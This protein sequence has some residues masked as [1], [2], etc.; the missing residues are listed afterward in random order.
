MKFY[1]TL[2]LFFG[3]FSLQAQVSSDCSIP[4]LLRDIYDRDVKGLA[5]KRMQA[6][7]S[8]DNALIQIPE[9]VQDSIYEGMAAILNVRD[10]LTEADSV[11]NLYCVHDNFSSPAV[12]GMIIGVD[13]DSPMATAWENSNTL[14]GVPVLDTLLLDQGFVLQNYISFGAGVFYSDQIWNIAAI[15]DSLVGTV[16]GIEY[17][18]PDY[19]IGGAGRIGYNTDP[20]GTRFYE[21]RYEWNDCFDGCDNFYTWNFAVAPDCSVTFTGSSQGGVF[22]NEPLPE[23]AN[24]LLFTDTDTPPV[25]E[26]LTL[27]PNPVQEVLQWQ[28]AP[29]SGSWRIYNSLGQ[30]IQSGNWQANE[31]NLQH[32][33][34]GIY[35][36]VV[37][38]EQGKHKGQHTLVKL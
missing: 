27:Y 3:L 18:E 8:P 15:A 34:K 31:L 12:Y 26:D 19:L 2:L 38:D 14:T 11:F 29:T 32:L 24:C 4:S 22:G 30:L 9:A 6:Q 23:P 25:A 28:N 5:L 16:A 33:T 20:D 37:L 21:F 13:T 17:V 7:D 1:S 10:Q 35:W 36:F